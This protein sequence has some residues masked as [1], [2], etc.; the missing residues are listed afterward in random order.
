MPKA[1]TSKRI[2]LIQTA[3]KLSFRNGFNSTSLANISREAEV[4][5][6]NVYY[7]FK[8]KNDLGEAIIEE[9]LT[10]LKSVLQHWSKAESPAERLCTFVHRAF[11]RRESITRSGCPIGTLCSELRKEGGEL[12]KK[13]SRLFAEQLSWLEAQFR[14]SGKTDD[15]RGAAIHLLAA[16]QGATVLANS[17]Q[18]SELVAIETERLKKWIRE[19]CD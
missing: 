12:S 16:I 17:L 8:T 10:K 1:A 15:P 4:P 14:E 7:Y 6:G 3:V 9:R 2:R 13:A 18:D 5:L 19:L 11:E